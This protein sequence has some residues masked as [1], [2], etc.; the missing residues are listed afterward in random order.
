MDEN[1][2]KKL[3]EEVLSISYEGVKIFEFRALP[4]QK[5]DNEKN[6][7]VPDSLTLFIMLKKPPVKYDDQTYVHTEDAKSYVR[8][9]KFLESLLGFECCVDFV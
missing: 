7:W 8:I 4:T 3:C 5:F 9:E 2:L 6:E 1:K